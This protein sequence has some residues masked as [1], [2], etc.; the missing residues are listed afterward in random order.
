MKFF[1]LSIFVF[2]AACS[3][4]DLERRSQLDRNKEKLIKVLNE[5]HNHFQLA[6]MNNHL[7]M[8]S[9]LVKIVK[10]LHVEDLEIAL[11]GSNKDNCEAQVKIQG[12]WKKGT[13]PYKSPLIVKLP[14][15][16][17]AREKLGF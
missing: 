17:I 12:M 4:K 9:D 8:E 10:P 15:D 1:V 13:E 2:L 7:L 11:I 14:L 5:M 3:Q 6:C 16:Y